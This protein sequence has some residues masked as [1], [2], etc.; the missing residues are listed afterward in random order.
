MGVILQI[1][2]F[3]F[4]TILILIVVAVLV[5]RHKIRSFLKNVQDV[6][7]NLA[8]RMVPPEIHL[9]P[10]EN[11]TWTNE[12]GMDAEVRPLAGLGFKS[13]GAYSAQEVEGLKLQAWVDPEKS[14]SAVAYDHPI[15]GIW[16]DFYTHYQDGTRIT[17]ANNQ[18]PT[19]VEHAPGHT[20]E[21]FPGLDSLSLYQKFIAARPDRPMR[22]M[23]PET[24]VEL[25]EK[26]YAEEMAWRNGPDGPAAKALEYDE[27]GNVIDVDYDSD[28][29]DDLDETL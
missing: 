28:E 8:S 15:A 12:A 21:R 4:L 29:L 1:L 24:F 10:L 17:Y 3:I 13:A 25:F 14:I 18:L 5:I 7:G 27:D 6:A 20:V 19:E 23:S 9:V 26:T 11:P 2:G 16:L 22:P